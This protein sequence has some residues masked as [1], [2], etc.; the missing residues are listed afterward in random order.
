MAVTES[1]KTPQRWGG[2][3]TAN[4][5]RGGTFPVY[6]AEAVGVCSGNY[7][8]LV[9]RCKTAR[10]LCEVSAALQ[11]IEQRWGRRD[12]QYA[13][14]CTL[15]LDLLLYGR[16]CQSDKPHLPRPDILQYAFVLR[17][18]AD[19]APDV[20]HPQNGSPSRPCGSVLMIRHSVYGR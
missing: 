9:A 1:A 5:Y 20:T 7:Y 19:L 17:P 18:L 10:T 16:L 6:E 13:G 4:L 14:C 8:N 12:P 2:R 11:A 3:V 15:D